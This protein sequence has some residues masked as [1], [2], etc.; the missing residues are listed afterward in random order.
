[1]HVSTALQGHLG[2]RLTQWFIGGAPR[3]RSE[4]VV[5]S[6]GDRFRLQ[7]TAAGTVHVHIGE[8]A[9]RGTPGDSW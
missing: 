5:Y 6:P 9:L 1:M 4:E 3:L 8:A 7:T 2:E